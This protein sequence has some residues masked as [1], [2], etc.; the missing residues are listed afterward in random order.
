MYQSMSPGPVM[1][2]WSTPT[3]SIRPTIT[4]AVDGVMSPMGSPVSSSSD[5]RALKLREPPVLLDPPDRADCSRRT[6]TGP[7]RL[8]ETVA[9][10]DSITARSPRQWLSK[11]VTVSGRVMNETRSPR[12]N[13]ST[14]ASLSVL[15]LRVSLS[16]SASISSASQRISRLTD[17]RSSA[18]SSSRSTLGVSGISAFP[19]LTSGG[20]FVNVIYRIEGE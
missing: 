19:N 10:P 20:R 9:L 8:A 4:S 17:W 7:A 15:R 13:S 2:T 16:A 14:T 18:A 5:S 1:T 12:C 11:P 3:T 6:T